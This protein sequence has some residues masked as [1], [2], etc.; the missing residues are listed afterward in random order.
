VNGENSGQRIRTTSRPQG[1]LCLRVATSERAT[2]KP[3]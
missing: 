1:F 3:S 2:R